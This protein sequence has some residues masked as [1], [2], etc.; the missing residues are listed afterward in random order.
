V[1]GK[2][3]LLTADVP[4]DRRQWEFT[5]KLHKLPFENR[6]TSGK[7]ARRWNCELERLGVAN[8]RMM[9]A[10][11]EI[12]HPCKADVISGIPAGF[13]RDWLSFH[14]RRLARKQFV[15]RMTVVMLG[16]VALAGAV[17]GVLLA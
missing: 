9:F 4:A 11:H 14:D 2:D 13:V 7:R 12:N 10:V 6:W 8:V 3:G 17:A 15:W 1:S 16:L 5:V